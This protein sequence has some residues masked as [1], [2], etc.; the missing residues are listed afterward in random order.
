[1]SVST[2]QQKG[3][4]RSMEWLLQSAL[5]IFSAVLRLYPRQFYSTF[6]DEM[7]DVFEM[8]LGDAVQAGIFSALRFL[9]RELVEYPVAL[10]LQHV[11]ERK[12]RSMRLLQ[13]NTL[14][15]IRATRWVAR[16]LSLLVGGFILVIFV[17][18]EDVRGDFNLCTVMLGLLSL[19]V[20][21]SWRWERIG[22]ML[23]MIGSPLLFL[24]LLIKGLPA[25]G[26]ITPIWVLFL[27]DT[28]IALAFL[29]IGWLFVS[30]AQHSDI[31]QVRVEEDDPGVTP[32]M[33]PR[34][35]LV[36]G[37]LGLLAL[38]FFAIPMVTPVQQR[39]EIPTFENVGYEQ[40]MN[41]L[42]VGGA[43]VGISSIPTE[44]P[45]LM[46]TGYEL[47]VDGEIV[48]VFEYTDTEAAAK[49][50]SALYYQKIPAWNEMDWSD[51]PHLYQVNNMLL[52]YVGSNADTISLLEET[53]STPF[54]EG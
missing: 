27:I 53:F 15:E 51:S 37:M 20:L 35:V 45:F 8:T 5:W 40:I 50:A 32:K 13:Y 14:G 2:G 31:T 38:V 54:L 24:V 25:D 29:I 4:N 3:A 11:Y 34:L 22:G 19:C 39:I 9:M 48:Q 41:Q 16:G 46:V 12:K 18:N 7:V 26:L 44:Q 52:L 33:K 36:V 6:A 43:V 28:S 23:T 21:A 1:M 49:D 47:D 42:R 17:F 10:I 30:L